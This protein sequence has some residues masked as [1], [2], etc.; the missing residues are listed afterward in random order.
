MPE[1]ITKPIG[2][3]GS[4]AVEAGKSYALLPMLLLLVF[5]LD[6]LPG[7]TADAQNTAMLIAGYVN[8]IVREVIGGAKLKERLIDVLDGPN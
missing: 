1:V 3:V 6:L 7:W 2:A 8:S 4:V 5:Q